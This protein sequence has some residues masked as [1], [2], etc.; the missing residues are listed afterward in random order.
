MHQIAIRDDFTDATTSMVIYPAGTMFK[1][2]SNE[3]EYVIAETM[4]GTEQI[5][6]AHDTY[7]TTENN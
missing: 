1:V 4:D 7:T 6:L 5:A 2:L 3:G